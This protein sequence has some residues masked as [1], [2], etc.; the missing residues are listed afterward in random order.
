[1]LRFL[2]C[3]LADSYTEMLQRAEM[4]LRDDAAR[5]R[6]AEEFVGWMA[7]Y[8]VKNQPVSEEKPLDDD[9]RGAMERLKQVQ[10]HCPPVLLVPGMF[11]PQPCVR[12]VCPPL[13][14]Q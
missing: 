4:R 6:E 3:G 1:M 10:L 2:V 9:D 7:A 11:S 14:L 12:V 13:L 5:A 8:K